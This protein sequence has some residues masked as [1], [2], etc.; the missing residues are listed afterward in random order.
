LTAAVGAHKPSEK[1]TVTLTRD[2]STQ[3]VTVTLGVRP[4]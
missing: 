2:G 1:I 3:K 4:S